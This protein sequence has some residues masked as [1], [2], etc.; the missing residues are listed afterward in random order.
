MK[1]PI[2]HGIELQFPCA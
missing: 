2:A 1:K